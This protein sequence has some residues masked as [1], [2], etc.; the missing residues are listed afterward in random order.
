MG[1]W[2]KA[3]R[4]LAYVIP[5]ALLAALGLAAPAAAAD[6]P[7]EIMPAHVLEAFTQFTG[8]PA[9]RTTIVDVQG[10]PDFDQALQIT[11]T[12]QPAS[13]GL[14]GEYSLGVGA[15][16]A[17]PTVKGEAMLATFWAR[18][19]TPTPTG[20][21]LAHFVF[22]QNGGGY[23][24]STQAAMKF[25][26]TWQRYRLPFRMAADYA[27]GQVRINFW[28]GYGPQVLQI[29]GVS[30]LR[31]GAGTPDGWPQ[32][33]YAGREAGAA[34][35]AAAA[36]RIER[37]RKGNLYV[38]VVDAEGHLVPGATVQADMTRHAFKFGSAA[39]GVR[40][41]T[42]NTS[43]QKYRDTLLANFNQFT[44]GNNLKWNHWENLPERNGYT[45]PA[46]QWG[47]D[48]GLFVRGHTLI[49]PS[50]GNMPADVCGLRGDPAALRSRIDAHITEE[51]GALAGLIDEWDVVNEPY[52]NHDVQDVL[53]DGELDR[54]F[55]LT[56]QADPGPRLYLND[57][58]IVE[59]NG[60]E[61][62]HQDHFTARVRAL[63]DGGAPIGGIGIQ[64]HFAGEQLTPP[65]DLVT[66]INRFGGLGLP[67][68][69]TEF[70]V[71]TTDE[72]LQADYTRDFLTTMFSMPQVTGVST[73][74]F[75]EG[76]TW[77]P[78][79][80]LFRTDWTLKPNGR[81]WRDLIYGTWWT[82]ATAT[83]GPT[84]ST[85]VRG[86]LGDYTVKVT[87]GGV[88]KEVAVSMP[89]ISGKA[90]TVVVG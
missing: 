43:A 36:D 25:G 41:M 56:R 34:W 55:R 80:A 86:F 62:R 5:G 4:R 74:G 47:R 11:V 27:A 69:I 28:L 70:D 46:L 38:K 31:Y 39:D 68:A 54:W 3:R 81:A 18:S 83:T 88:T 48:H 13:P 49:W 63:K 2:T 59:D 26:G 52:A 9:P 71:G 29:A 23:T 30:V 20:S 16:S 32:A 82:K 90:I 19:I 17:L 60:W 57:Y 85:T 42:Q 8:N 65:A 22:E 45:L 84:G 37:N 15:P 6:P 72:Q 75:W 7:T 87:A 77:D 67:V 10:Q 53:G 12:G 35:R 51:A 21:G 1:R 40:L 24:K 79:R 66:L 73:F 78:K 14:D 61:A 89:T 50:C 58:D 44:L 76:D 64:G 33:T